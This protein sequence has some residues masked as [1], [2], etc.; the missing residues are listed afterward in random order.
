MTPLSARWAPALTALLLLSLPPVWL[1]ALAAPTRDDC[2]AP[3][4]FFGAGRIGAVEVG[5]AAAPGDLAN[6]V[7]GRAHTA[8]PG[9]LAVRAIRTFDPVPLYVS[10]IAFGFDRSLY[11]GPTAVRRVAAGSEVLP[12]HW[13]TREGAGVARI[14]AW[15]FVHGGEP[16]RHPA[17]SGLALALPQLLEGTRPVTLLI[18]SAAGPLEALPA[19][20][21][22]TERW[23]AD[24]WL[25]LEAACRF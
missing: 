19:L 3:A 1:H 17:A 21:R 16:V 8:G 14:E 18:A 4:A 6:A 25:E 12:V 23:L 20:E 22:A 24:A 13:S 2:A 10:P 5:P 15:V 11:L 7:E 9:R